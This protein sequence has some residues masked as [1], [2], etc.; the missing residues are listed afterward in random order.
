MF[1]IPKPP[2]S[3]YDFNLVC[4]LLCQIA[5][6]GLM[7]VGSWVMWTAPLFIAIILQI[8]LKSAKDWDVIIA[9]APLINDEWKY[10]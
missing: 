5:T 4:I 1:G 8:D 3:N 2:W 10:G 9:E 6:I 7:F